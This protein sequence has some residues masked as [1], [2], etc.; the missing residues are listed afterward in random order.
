MPDFVT[1]TALVPPFLIPHS[2]LNS[3]F[4]I[5]NSKFINFQLPAS[6][7]F[8]VLNSSLRHIYY[9][10]IN[11]ETVVMGYIRGKAGLCVKLQTGGEQSVT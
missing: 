9:Y 7:K 8:K 5:P 10:G 4:H 6:A 2:L 1:I 11:A 3:T